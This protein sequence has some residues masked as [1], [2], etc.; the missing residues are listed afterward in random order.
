MKRIVNK[1][2]AGLTDDE[3]SEMMRLGRAR[4]VE[5]EKDGV[6][7][8]SGDVT[9]ELGVVL[10]GSV[11]IENV[12]VWG[13]VGIL[14]NVSRGHVFAET[15]AF[16]GVPLMVDVVAAEKC[17]V[18]FLRLAPLIDGKSDS[19]WQ[20]KFVAN[21]LGLLT[22][23]NLTLS[24]RIFC[25]SPKSIRAR[26]MTYLSGEAKR[27]G[28]TSFFIPFDRRRMADYLNVERTALSKELSKM[29]SDGLIR[30]RK[31]R[32]ELLKTDADF[33]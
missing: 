28:S 3:Y 20:K 16:L 31:N 11:N 27:T 1:L 10:F 9:D 22:E 32:F 12:D 19:A 21:T 14:D 2:F 24:R 7:L 25:S 17:G 26:V 5:Y 18:L 15:Y 29:Q 6:V 8:H 4:E 13:N 23:K 33:F 30:F